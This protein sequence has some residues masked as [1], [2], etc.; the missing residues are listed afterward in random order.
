MDKELILTH[1]KV[2]LVKS[3]D[4]SYL[5][6]DSLNSRYPIK[7]YKNNCSKLFNSLDSAFKIVNNFDY[8]KNIETRD[9]YVSEIYNTN[10]NSLRLSVSGFVTE[11]GKEYLNIF[12]RM[13]YKPEN[14]TQFM[15]TKTCVKFDA[16]LDT[17]KQ[18]EQFYKECFL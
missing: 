18:L 13:W 16:K 17:T 15:S 11:N 5:T 12:L 10:N 6:F 8:K 14:E 9:Y 2:K 3:N 1:C 7:I 4:Q